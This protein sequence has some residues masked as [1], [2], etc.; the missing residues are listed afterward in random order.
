MTFP[1]YRH[2]LDLR[3]GARHPEQGDSRPIQPVAFAV[4]AG[5]RP[6]GLL[7]LELPL[8]DSRPPEIL[9]VF[10][11]PE[12]RRR[13][14]AA[15]LVEAAELDV[16]GRGFAELEAVYTT[17]RPGSAIAEH[18][19]ERRGWQ[20]PETRT[21][22]V[23]I[24]PRDFLASSLLAPERAAA[25][26]PGFEYFAW[27]DL[28][29]AE[30]QALIDSDTR[31]PWVTKGLWAWK[32]D[33]EGFDRATS[34]GVRWGGEIVGWVISQRIDAGSVRYLASFLRKDLSRRSRILPL[35]RESLGR[36]VRDGVELA[37]WVT[38]MLYPSMIKFIRKWM[39]PH[40]RLVAETRGRKIRFG[41]PDA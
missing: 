12:F 20:A 4:F 3:P 26:D 14:V 23:Q 37:T 34:L 8:G 27:A 16:R 22:L 6:A 21:V 41:D 19:L 40:A 32:Y 9:S 36:G 28:D 13:G 15:A 25:L 29:P 35:Y 30:R 7:L 10:V 5:E 38:P 11:A 33:T 39:A 1:V 31:Q 18:L 17:G 24:V 2:L